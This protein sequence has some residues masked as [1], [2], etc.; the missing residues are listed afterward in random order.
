MKQKHKLS[1]QQLLKKSIHVQF[2][3]T[4]YFLHGQYLTIILRFDCMIHCKM[5]QNLIWV[6]TYYQN[7]LFFPHLPNVYRIWEVLN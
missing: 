5:L 3:V 2:C 4:L 1:T 6:A 7:N